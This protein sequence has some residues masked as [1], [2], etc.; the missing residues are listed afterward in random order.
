MPQSKRA[1]NPARHQH[2]CERQPY[3]SQQR[4][5]IVQIAQASRACPARQRSRPAHWRPIIAMSR[6][7]PAAIACLI[8]AGIAVM[9]R[10][11]KPKAGREDEDQACE[12]HGAERD[13]H[14]TFMPMT[15][16]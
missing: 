7:M 15:T 13:R 16:E 12:R 2:R 8:E 3:A 1:R 4:R 11:R 5:P 6:P 10:S 14:G 9:R